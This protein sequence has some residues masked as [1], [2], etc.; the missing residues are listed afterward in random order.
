[1]SDPQP[2]GLQDGGGGQVRIGCAVAHAVFQAGSC[3]TFDGDAHGDAAVIVAPVGPIAGQLAGTQALVS[4][5]RRGAQGGHA[6]V[7]LDDPGDALVGQGGQ[8]VG[9][10]GVSQGVV[11]VLIL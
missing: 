4:V 7:M 3:S 5:D 9:R 8:A 6:L 1:M 10:L 11:G 2:S